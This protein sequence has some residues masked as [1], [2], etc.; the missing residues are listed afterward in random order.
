MRSWGS[1]ERGPRA[2]A[3][4]ASGAVLLAILLGLPALVQAQDPFAAAVAAYVPGSNGG[5]GAER[6]PDIVLGPPHGGGATQGSLHVLAL[7]IGGSITLEFAPRAICN[8]P[9]PDFTIFENA[10][11]IGSS[12]GPL[13][14][15]Y[16]YVAVSQNGMDFIEFPY[17]PGTGAGLAGRTPVFSHPDNGID[18]LDPSVSGGD[19]FDLDAIGL[20]WVRYVRITDVAGAIPDVGDMPQFTLAPN[21]GF[22]LDAAA[23]LHPCNPLDAATPTAS[24][25]TV[26][27]SPTTTPMSAET[28]T[29]VPTPAVPTATAPTS[30]AA[31]PTPTAVPAIPGDLDGDGERTAADLS[32]LIAAIFADGDTVVA[33]RAADLN[34]DARVTA[35]DIVEFA[36]LRTQ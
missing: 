11:H 19:T 28:P 16:A 8:G 32:L 36:N 25:T 27:V 13:F 14:T 12:A 4:L 34:G 7:G 5:F 20:D 29:A 30:D 24:P 17:D 31:T 21:A 6:L 23:A 9:G 1:H 15:E 18:P 3:A 22:D 26:P 10:F 33:G 2:C 35:A